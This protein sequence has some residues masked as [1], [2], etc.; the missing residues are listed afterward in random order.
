M[1]IL[2]KLNPRERKTVLY[3][4]AVSVLI[5]GYIFLVDPV[6]Q[7]GQLVR[8]QLRMFCWPKREQP[9]R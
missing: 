6:V 4:A 7:G 9:R 2:D 5:F 3:S 8:G 1:K